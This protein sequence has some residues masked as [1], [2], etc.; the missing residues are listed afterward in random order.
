M[1]GHILGYV[2]FFEM[3]ARDIGSYQF[4][5]IPPGRYLVVVNPSGPYDDWPYDLQYYPAGVRKNKARVFELAPGQRMA[6]INFQVPRLPGAKT[7]SCELH[8]QMDAAGCPVCI[9]Y[10]N[11]DDY[12]SLVGKNCIGYTDQNGLAMIHTYGKSELRLFAEQFVY[13]DNR[14]WPDRFHSQ[15]VNQTDQF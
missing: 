13:H 9:A 6:G 5:K 4:R 1:A 3:T 12:E 7:L 11:T 8:G 15:P 14:R 2:N 10:T